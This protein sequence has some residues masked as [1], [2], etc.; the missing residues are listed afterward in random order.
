[1][2]TFD[3]EAMLARRRVITAALHNA[4]WDP[5]DGRWTEVAHSCRLAITRGR[6]RWLGT[7][8][9][10]RDERLVAGTKSPHPVEKKQKKRNDESRLI[11]KVES[12]KQ[13][14]TR[15]MANNEN[16]VRDS[17]G[18]QA[19]L[20]FIVAKR[21]AFTNVPKS[22]S[23]HVFDPQKPQTTNVPSPE[24]VCL[25]FKPL[26]ILTIPSHFCRRRSRLIW[27]HRHSGHPSVR[28]HH[29]YLT[30]HPLPWCCLTSICMVDHLFRPRRLGCAVHALMTISSN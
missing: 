8:V 12:W 15:E 1:M 13:T 2:D 7:R 11:Q 9:E 18:T 6:H 17:P 4:K 14:I 28:N 29:P 22:S 27:L 3:S 5:A 30:I 24:S 23:R 16:R 25:H 19:P 10:R 26:S 21:S 20:A